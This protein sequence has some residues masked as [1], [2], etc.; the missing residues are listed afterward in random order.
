MARCS[1][2]PFIIEV[3]DDVL[4]DLRRRIRSTRWPDPAPGEA[5]SQGVDREFLQNL[6]TYWADGFDWRAQEERLNRYD[7]RI[8]DIDGIRL[9][10]VG[11]RGG[12]AAPAHPAAR[13]AELVP[14]DA[15]LG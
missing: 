3:P 8:A 11:H 4:D 9:H 10:F 15:A 5:W 1:S 14:R 2:E 7:H 6:L 12:G 13:L